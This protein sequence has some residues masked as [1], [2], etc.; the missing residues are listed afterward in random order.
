VTRNPFLSIW[1]SP[2]ET[3]REIVSFDPNYHVLLLAALQGIAKALDR[4]ST[5]NAGDMLSLPVILGI[6]VVLGPLGGLFSLWLGSHLLRWTG[7]WIGGM[8]D[9]TEIKAAIAWSGVPLIVS[10]AVVAVE[11]AVFGIDVFRSEETSAPLSS[12]TAILLLN[13]GLLQIMLGVW[14]LVLFCNTLAEVQQFPSA[15]KGLGNAAL[16]GLVIIGP[17]ISIVMIAGVVGAMMR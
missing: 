15:W 14:S 3:I 9:R 6:A 11:V 8:A 5:K 4:A 17:I 13:L 16:V 1:T 2:R 10:L 7:S 12:T